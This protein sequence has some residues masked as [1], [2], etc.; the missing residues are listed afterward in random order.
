MPKNTQTQHCEFYLARYVPNLLDNKSLNVGVLLYCPGIGFMGCRFIEDT[1][2]I[3]GFHAPADL[4]FFAQLQEYFERQIEEHRDD[5]PAF[6]REVQT[7]S[8]IVQIGPPQECATCD[9]EAEIRTLFERYV[10]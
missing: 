7:Y 6:L 1:A 3:R 4:E 10:G 2:R 9:P 5:L 8:N